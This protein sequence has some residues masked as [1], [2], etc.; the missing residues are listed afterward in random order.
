MNDIADSIVTT[1]ETIEFFSEGLRQA[2][3]AARQL[4]KAQNHP[5]WMDISCLLDEL[6]NSGVELSRK[7]SLGRQKTLQILD[8]YETTMSDKLEESRS[9]RK[10]KF[11][12]N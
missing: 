10:P 11:L 2:A 8:R 3:S 1:K 6:H 7:K 4:A 9:V 12:L 5:I